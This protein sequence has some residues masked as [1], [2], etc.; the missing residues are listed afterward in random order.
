M[1]G[2]LNRRL[3][4]KFDGLLHVGRTTIVLSM[5]TFD[6]LAQSDGAASGNDAAVSQQ[7]C[8]WIGCDR[9]GLYR[10]PRSRR[11]LR[12]YWWFCLEHVRAYNAAWNYYAGMS[13][14]EVEADVRFDTVWQRPSWPLGAMRYVHWRARPVG[15]GFSPFQETRTPAQPAL[16][17]EER[18][19]L[20]LDLRPPVTVNI[21]KTR[22]KELVKLHHPDAN[23]G[24]KASEERF[25]QIS[26]AYR[27][28]MSSLTS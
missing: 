14:N 17:P 10:A 23:G 24:D 6:R 9:D 12:R 4:G 15:G 1:P 3:D 25:K 7:R 8:Q 21:V 18:A 20:V 5:R 28:V 11:E 19:L 26:E 22:Y 2:L 13:D 16:T 27:K